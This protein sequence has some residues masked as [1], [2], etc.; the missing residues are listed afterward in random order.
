MKHTSFLLSCF[1]CFLLTSHAIS[2]TPQIVYKT[3][4]YWQQQADYIMEIDM[5]VSTYQFTGKQKIIYTNNSPDVL[6]KV[7]Y[8]LYFNAFQPGSEMDMKAQTIADPSKRMVINVGEKGDPI[9]E[10]KIA[11]LQP[12][13]IGYINVIA[14]SQNGIALN[15]NVEGTVLEVQLANTIQPGEHVEFDMVF[16]GQVPDQ[17]RRSGRSN[18]ENVALSMSQWYPK[19]AEYDD[20]GW[21]AYSYIGREFYGVWGNYD[22]KITIDKNYVLGG[23]GYLQNPNEIGHGYET[24]KVKPSKS[25]KLTW[26]FIAPNVHD[27][28]WA[29]DPDYNHDTLNV[30]NGPTLHFLYKNT[31]APEKLENWKQLQPKAAKLMTYYSD[32]VGAYPYKQYSII[33]GGDGGMEYGMCT[34]INGEDN[35]ESMFRST[36]SHEMA[37]TWFQF[38]LATN[39]AKHEWM[40]EGFSTYIEYKAMDDFYNENKTNPWKRS[41]S[42][43]INIANSGLE[44]PQTTYADKYELNNLYSAASYHKGC[45]FLAQLGYVIG[46]DNLVKTIKKYYNNFAFK[47]PKPIDIIRTAEKISGIELDWYLIDFT[48]TTNTIDYAVKSIDTKTVTL[49]RIGLMAMPIDVRITYTDGSVEDFYIP[50]RQMRGEKPTSATLLKDWAWVF[51]TY[52]FKTSKKVASVQIDPSSLMADVNSEDNL[53][54]KDKNN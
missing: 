4:G 12:D 11:K 1:V 15:Y 35:L 43:Y 23:T 18:L 46:E 24:S 36:V 6:D 22:V 14:L 50:L 13:E 28:A 38:L 26:H 3:D 29:A 42:R 47:H 37:H 31:M 44:Q 34:L 8:H 41:Y 25:D 54:L 51:P 27:F 32:L 49:E 45:V 9:Y 20:E 30:E 7:F 10:S 33:Q 5:N 53:L 2:Q 16:K 39:E 40:D 19:L 52:S 21:H 48:Q 17:I